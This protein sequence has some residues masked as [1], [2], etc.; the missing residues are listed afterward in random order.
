MHVQHEPRTIY[1]HKESLSLTEACLGHTN[2]LPE[3][4]ADVHAKNNHGWTP[5]HCAL[6]CDKGHDIIA[7]MLPEKGA[8][9]SE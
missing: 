1:H 9:D 8:V 3:K 5:L 7:A 2:A 4:G 6:A